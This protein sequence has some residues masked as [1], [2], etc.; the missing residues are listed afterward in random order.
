MQEMPKTWVGRSLG[1]GNGNPLQ[2]SCLRNP[3]DEEHGGYGSRGR[4]ESDTTERI[5][6]KSLPNRRGFLGWHLPMCSSQTLSAPI[7]CPTAEL[8]RTRGALGNRRVTALLYSCNLS[9][10]I[11][12]CSHYL[13][14]YTQ[15]YNLLS[16][17]LMVG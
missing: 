12:L 6:R 11:C 7:V 1:G 2:C 3:T 16:S 10:L 5:H 13:L 14:P 4:K 8:T 15:W 17:S 9:F